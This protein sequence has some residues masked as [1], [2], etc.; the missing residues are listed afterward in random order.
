MMDGSSAVLVERGA[1]KTP[2][3]GVGCAMEEL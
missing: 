2:V 1:W 3:C